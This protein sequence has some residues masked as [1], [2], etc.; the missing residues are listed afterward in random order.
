MLRRSGRTSRAAKGDHRS[1]LAPALVALGFWI[2]FPGIVAHQDMAS[3][4]SGDERGAAR[5]SNFV[6]RSVAGSVH[7][8]EMPF[9][10]SGLKT[11]GISGSGMRAPGIGAVALRS[12]KRV[13][14]ETPDEERI[15]R[16]EKSG[17]LVEVAPMLPPKLFNAGSIFEQHTSL[18]RQMPTDGVRMTFVKPEI[19]GK[20]VSIASAFY[21]KRE[22]KSAGGLPTAIAELVN[23]D[24]PDILATAYAPVKPD[25]AKASPF[26]SILREEQPDAGRFIPP[27]GAKDHPW[28]RKALPASVF[29]ESEQRCLAAGIYFEARGESVKG[30]AAVAQ[31]I[32]NRVRNPTYPGSICGVVYQNEKWRNRCQFSFACDGIRDRVQSPAHFKMAQDVAMATTAGKIWLP[33]V[34]SATHYHATYVHPRWANAMERMKKIGQHIFYRTYGGGWN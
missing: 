16:A 12:E 4:I 20:E 8:A 2:G 18:L 28:A 11:A 26:A 30:Q 15:N 13:A 27:V 7:K 21:M 23:N 17:R 31:V 14:P 33:E 3:F 19:K 34:G 24:R 29:S 22:K 9:V 32:L 6:E 5:W 10:D 25:Y 1:V